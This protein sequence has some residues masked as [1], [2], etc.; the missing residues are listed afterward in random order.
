[1]S[2]K[3]SRT[4]GRADKARFSSIPHRVLDS[5]AFLELSSNAIK[6]LVDLCRQY[7]GYNNGDLQIAWSRMSRRGWAS[8]Q[9]LY[10]AKQQLIEHG[11]IA[12]ARQGGRH[13]C[14]LYALGWEGIN[15]C[16]GKHDLR[17][18]PAH[19]DWLRYPDNC[20]NVLRKAG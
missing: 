9:T 13:A 11:L 1:M 14:S 18:G 7:N 15:E 4:T 6:L 8:K 19:N 20:T 5:P 16:K 3:R 17:P 2:Q 10:N 12:L